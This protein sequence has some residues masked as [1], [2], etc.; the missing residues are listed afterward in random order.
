M[1]ES[2]ED[3]LARWERLRLLQGA[4]PHFVDF[5]RDGMEFL[6]FSTSD[7]QEDIGIYIECGPEA[8]MV[9]AQRSQ[10]KTTIAA[11]YA[12]WSLIHAPKLRVLIISAGGRQ[13]NE[14]ST[15]VV[16]VILNWDILECLC[17]D[18]QAGDRTSVEAF[19]VHHSLKGVDKSP[20]VAC[21]GITANLQGA[22]ADLL[23]ADDIESTKNGLTALQRQQLLHLTLDFVSICRDGR[24][25]WLGTPQTSDSIYNTLP[26]RG[27][28]VRIWPGR[29]PTAAQR[30]H[31]G[32]MLAP[33]LVRRMEA[34][35]SICIG[36]GALGDQGKPID[37]LL[38]NEKSLQTK[39]LDQGSAYFQLQHMLST[40]LTDALRHPLKTARMLVM[41]LG[42]N[43]MVPV[44][45]VPGVSV[46][47]LRAYSVGGYKFML[48]TP[49]STAGMM[50]KLTAVVMYIDPAPGGVNGDESGYAIVGMLNGNIFVLDVGGV[51]GGY[52]MDKMEALADIAKEWDVN[53]VQIEKNMGY[54]AFLQIFLPILRAKHPTSEIKED[55]VTGQKETRICAT[56]EPVL[57]RGS[58][59][60]NEDIIEKDWATAQRYGA[61][62]A[63]TYS[64][65]YQ[66][67]KLTRDKNSLSHD[68]R[69]DAL[70]GAVRF[71]QEALALSQKEAR[72]RAEALAYAQFTKDPLGR[73]RYGNP[74]PQGSSLLD[75]IKGRRR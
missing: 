75:R 10:A 38:M 35:P 27:V 25:I 43:R 29:Y 11:L 65:F 8:L 57:G 66:L 74:R 55:Y 13:A 47:N 52:E 1:K 2:V 63:L 12:V 22:R 67:S 45:V 64:F 60:I 23:I 30:D 32:D 42:K 56:L 44:E 21:M 26:G 28:T 9:Q 73:G 34:D 59:V 72:K 49:A 20:S 16:R 71:F 3:G 37:N 18:K 39:E 61:K 62:V 6:G 40:K 48:N 24:I 69:V 14:I 41:R 53:V 4:Y 17:P 7:I 50:A 31:Y 19:D 5:L 54:G 46:D 70:E 36:G 68:D 58:L 33:L 51:P 15:L